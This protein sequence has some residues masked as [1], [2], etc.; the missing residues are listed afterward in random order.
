[1][2]IQDTATQFPPFAQ[3]WANKRLQRYFNLHAQLPT[4]HE[5]AGVKDYL[6]SLTEEDGFSQKLNKV[7]WRDAVQLQK[8][9]HEDIAKKSEK[10][11]KISFGVTTEGKFLFLR[12]APPEGTTFK[13]VVLNK[14]SNIKDWKWNVTENF[15]VYGAPLETVSADV[16]FGGNVDMR[17]ANIKHWHNDVAGDFHSYNSSL[18]TISNTAKFGGKFGV[19]NSNIKD[20][21]HDFPGTFTVNDSL[22]ATSSDSDKFGGQFSFVSASPNIKDFKHDV[23]GTFTAEDLSS[24]PYPPL[25]N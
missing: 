11:S 22:A 24:E 10:M 13:T 16:K 2:R 15:K 6:T 5:I 4:E 7:S 23:P 3:D 25:F 8:N 19:V 18:E 21:K 14:D 12:E 1:M 9:W 20:F 17:D